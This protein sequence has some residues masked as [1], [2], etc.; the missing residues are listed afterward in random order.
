MNKMTEPQM[1]SDTPDMNAEKSNILI[2]DDN[3]FNLELLADVIRKQGYEPRPVP[4]GRLALVAAQ[5]DPPDLI[6]LDINMANMNGF[7]VCKRLKADAALKD[8]PV[9]FITGLNETAD[10]VKAF[11]MGAVDYITKPFQNEEVCARVETHMRLRRLQK[12]VDKYNNHLEGVV[13]EKIKE[14]PHHSILQ[15]QYG[16]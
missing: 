2:V 7:E 12:E 8:I 15:H 3:P 4:N 10:K 9:I 13:Q 11:S 5:K 6:L 16:A 14:Y 1:P